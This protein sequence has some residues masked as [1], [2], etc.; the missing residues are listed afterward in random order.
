MIFLEKKL[1]IIRLDK[2]DLQARI[3]MIL[4]KIVKIWIKLQSG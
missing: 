4:D 3:S 1:Q 2:V